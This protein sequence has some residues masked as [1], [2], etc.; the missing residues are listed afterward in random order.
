MELEQLKK[1]S[2]RVPGL[3]VW[4][5]IYWKHGT[6][7]P[8]V[9]ELIIH[10]MIF[11]LCGKQVGHLSVCDWLK[12]ATDFIKCRTTAVILL[13]YH[14]D[15]KH[16]K[17]CVDRQT[18]KV[19]VNASSLATGV[20]LELVGADV[21]DTCSLH[22]VKD[23]QHINLAEFHVMLKGFKLVLQWSTTKC[24]LENPEYTQKLQVKCSSDDDLVC[25]S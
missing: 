14:I 24:S 6:M 22:L 21:E 25:C 3:Y 16:N 13:S 7:V 9:P 4:K 8:E 19:K 15:P 17:W 5:Q 12:V 10:G 2:A 18:L 11:S 1:C 23:A 20:L